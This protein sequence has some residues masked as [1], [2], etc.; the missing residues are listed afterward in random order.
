MSRQFE[1]AASVRVSD[2]IVKGRETS[3]PVRK[4]V[5]ARPTTS[6]TLV[7]THGGGFSHGGLDQLESHAVAASIAAKGWTVIAVD[8]RLVPPWSWWR[9]PRSGR[10][11]GT[12][13]PL[14]LNDVEDVVRATMKGAGGDVYLGGASAGACLSAAA[15]LR[16]ARAGA[17]PRGLVLAYGSFHA[18]LPP[19]SREL[20]AR[21]RGL[22]G[23]VQFRPGTVE[24]MNRNYAGSPQAMSDPFAFPGGHDLRGLPP[25]LVMDADRDS[26]RASGE[27]FGRELIAAGVDTDYL[28]IPGTHHGFLDRPQD[29]TFAPGIDAILEWL[30]H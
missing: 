22:H 8:Y 26:L 4:Y 30:E 10:L 1:V 7:W 20:A 9:P 14:P 12:R 16:L 6:A 25:A 2:G 21:L 24:K 11:E 18:K 27:L 3:I 5:P 23:I 17:A 19:G 15:A 13:F 28:V 29:R